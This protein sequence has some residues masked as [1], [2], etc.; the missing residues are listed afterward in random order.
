LSQ[1]SPPAATKDGPRTNDEI[2]NAQIQLT[3]RTA[4]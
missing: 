4:N 1:Q 2:R 3:I